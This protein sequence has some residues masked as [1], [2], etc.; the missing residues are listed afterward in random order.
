[1]KIFSIASLC[2]LTAGLTVHASSTE[3]VL[4]PNISCGDYI[5]ELNITSEQIKSELKKLCNDA[6]KGDGTA[7]FSLGLKFATGEHDIDPDYRKAS[8]WFEKSANLQNPK[9]AFNLGVFYA[10]GIGV[11]KNETEATRLF[12]FAAERGLPNAQYNLGIRY[13]LGLGVPENDVLATKWFEEAAKH[14]L[15]DAQFNLGIRYSKGLGIPK[16]DVLAYSWLN[17][18]SGAGFDD[19]KLARDLIAQGMT[20]DQISQAQELSR[21]WASKERSSGKNP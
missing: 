9:G 15:P 17:L 1:M 10:Q 21:R 6:S 16:D 19:A 11:Q 4:G 20:E 13:S 18:A 3:Q 2:I 12:G 7:A 8:D 14:G 5:N